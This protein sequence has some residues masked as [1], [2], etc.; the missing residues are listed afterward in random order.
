M[1]FYKDIE[2][3]KIINKALSD[4]A[5]FF[6]IGYDFDEIPE[7]L[8]EL[9][10]PVKSPLFLIKKDYKNILDLGCGVGA[11]IFLISKKLRSSLVC[12]MDT[13]HPLLKVGKEIHSLEVVNGD[14]FY[15]PF[16]E[17]VFDLVI[18]NGTFNQINEKTLL[19]KEIKR[20]LK[21]DGH[22][23]ICDIYKKKEVG[24]LEE[25]I[26]FNVSYA[27][28]KEDLLNFFKDFGFAFL[29]GS[30]NDEF[31][32]EFGIFSCLWKVL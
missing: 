15:A 30:F 6:N 22:L 8:R 29:D 21:S 9:A 19:I 25:G 20:V 11:D 4:K 10:L 12:G 1:S 31:T 24:E 18:M 3:I 23:I 32:E 17:S 27:L 2:R 14:A 7:S 16:K 28:T 5:F 13:S 26:S